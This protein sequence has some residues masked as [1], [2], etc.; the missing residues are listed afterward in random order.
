MLAQDQRAQA[1]DDDAGRD[2][3][4]CHLVHRLGEPDDAPSPFDQP[5]GWITF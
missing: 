1:D 4:R 2:E 5:D 3:T